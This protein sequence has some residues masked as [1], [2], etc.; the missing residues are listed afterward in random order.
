MG[1]KPPKGSKSRDS[2]QMSHA[3]VYPIKTWI[4]AI[5]PPTQVLA[6]M[7]YGSGMKNKG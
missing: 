6:K 2:P 4:F 5:L 3:T 7:A 1:S